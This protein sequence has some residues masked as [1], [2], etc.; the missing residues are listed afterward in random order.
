M[1]AKDGG[2]MKLY[3][4][5]RKEVSSG[6]LEMRE[7]TVCCKP[8]RLRELAAFIT[9]CADGMEK[10]S[11]QWDHEHFSDFDKVQFIVANP[12]ILK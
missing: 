8:E 1:A 3:G 2:G 11:Q 5:K 6:L 12:R 4:Y 10:D 9:R 7:V